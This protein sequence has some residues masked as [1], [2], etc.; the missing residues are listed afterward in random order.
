MQKPI[1]FP[2]FFLLWAKRQGWEVPDIH[3][4]I[5]HWLESR[6]GR[7]AVLRVFRGVGKSTILSIYNAWVYYRNP[8]FR[9]LHQ[10]D[11]DAT[12]YK[13]SRDTKN[14][15]EK[16]PL[17]ADMARSIKGDIAFW[18]TLPGYENDPRNPSMQAVGILSNIVSSRADEIQ[19]DDVEVQKNVETP[20]AR[21]KLRHRLSEQIHIG[22]PGSKRLFIGTPHTH[23][24]LYDEL[25]ESGAE[26]FTL[27]LFGKEKRFTETETET[28]YRVPFR[29]E[30]I[31]VG[32]GKYTK[33]L[34]EGQGYAFADGMVTLPEPPRATIDCYAQNAWPERF[35][36]DEM[37]ERRKQCR[38]LNE[39]D[40]QYQLHAK[41]I[42]EVRL[43]P[44]KIIP[45][46]ITPRINRANHSIGMWLGGVQIVGAAAYWDCALGK[47]GS[48][49]SVFALVLTDE[50][51]RLYLQVCKALTGTVDDQSRAIREYVVQYQIPRIVVETNG[52][53]GF[54][55]PILRKHLAKTGC[56]VGEIFQTSNKNKRILDA[57]EAPL[58]SGFLWAH[59]DVLNSP[60]WDQMMEWN[61]AVK[62]QPDDYL[63]AGA[64]AIAE[65]PVRIGKLVGKPNGAE[66]ENWRPNHGQFEVTLDYDSTSPNTV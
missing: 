63:D 20:E 1:S 50:P 60:M 12:A 45:Y 49:A 35:T 9:I 37:A 5:C 10:G 66:R 31:F 65:T 32:V 26:H 21:E 39:W 38:T 41:P 46:D 34:R 33:V 54:V 55:P 14:I 15:L 23:N 28:R 59:V 64:G 3:I 17:T 61:P 11:Q 18:W 47:I 24:S 51:G 53:G 16:H 36:F 25:I 48:D 13:T 43:N 56:G 8:A 62:S 57:W 4:A 6:Q 30:I 58:D 29:P 42:V 27:P 7:V 44:E 40:S 52:P 2:A 19:N 22:V